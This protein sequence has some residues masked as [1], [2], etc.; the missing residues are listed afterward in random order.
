MPAQGEGC[1]QGVWQGSRSHVRRLPTAVLQQLLLPFLFFVLHP[2]ASN[3]FSALMIL[4]LAGQEALLH[5]WG[6]SPAPEK[7]HKAI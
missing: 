7:R 5:W 3:V 1:L 4:V 6:Q 2:P